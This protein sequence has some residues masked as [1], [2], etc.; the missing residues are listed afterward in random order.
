MLAC[1][2]SRSF[3]ASVLTGASVDTSSTLPSITTV[4]FSRRRPGR[5]ARRQAQLTTHAG[6]IQTRKFAGAATEGLREPDGV[7]LTSTRNQVVALLH[8]TLSLVPRTLSTADGAVGPESSTFWSDILERA[9]AELVSGSIQTPPR[10]TIA[11]CGFDNWAGSNELVTGLLED[12]F[13][14]DSTYSDILRNRWNSNPSSVNIEYG[15]PVA[16][17]GGLRSPSIWLQQFPHDVQ[18]TELPDLSSL[19][20]IRTEVDS[21][22]SSSDVLLFVC[23]PVTTSL[24]D[25]VNGAKHLLNKPNTILVLTS[26]S[27][28]NHHHQFTSQSL[29]KLGC[30]PGHIIFVDLK[31]AL[32]AI[33]TLQTN[34]GSA[35]AIDKYQTDWLG[36][37]ISAIGAAVGEIFDPKGPSDKSLLGL[38]QATAL[39]QIYSALTASS[40]SVQG[41]EKEVDFVADGLDTLRS[42]VQQ[43][44]AKAV[45]EILGEPGKDGKI[46]KALAQG[47]K[48]MNV[49]LGS[50]TFWKMVWRV[51]EI[52]AVVSAAIQGQWCKE[53]ENQLILQTGRL[54][55]TQRKLSASAFSL[56]SSSSEASLLRSAVLENRLQQ[57]I[58]S[59]AYNLTPSTLTQPI[60]DRRNQLIRYTTTKLHQEA[61]SAVVGAFGGVLT[62]A[63]LGWWLA[64]GDHILSLGIGTETGTATG[65]GALLAVSSIRWA[66]GKW[67][68]AKQRWTRDAGRVGEGL[69]RDIQATIQRTVD[70]KLVIVATTACKGLEDLIGRRRDELQQLYNELQVL[71]AEL[72]S[73]T[74]HPT[75]CRGS[76]TLFPANKIDIE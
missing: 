41:V 33:T 69:S 49:L 72:H 10:A 21:L 51:D 18:L 39:S 12:P 7:E 35:S 13:S 14:T 55:P 17:S 68:R 65:V 23:D 46:G 54:E 26:T 4:V 61:Q 40:Q 44:Q 42:E 34:P 32:T 11:V 43:I 60:H 3:A 74:R 67:E 58:G 31:R 9:G 66:V 20:A 28:S 62:G 75:S 19:Y 47:T 25:L 36:S 73:C 6:W 22:L 50:F 64:F 76:Q 8:K 59:P 15:N 5:C 27:A 70:D 24:S 1:L 63:G 57:L 30:K 37:R 48:E 71:E 45:T 16:V 2:V 56:L 52:G 53:L 29:S 38:K